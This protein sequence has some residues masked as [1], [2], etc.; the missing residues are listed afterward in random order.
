MLNENNKSRG[1]EY[2][3]TTKSSRFAVVFGVAVRRCPWWNRWR[4]RDEPGSERQTGAAGGRMDGRD[5]CLSSHSSSVS[6]LLPSCSR[7]SQPQ[8]RV[9]VG[10]DKRWERRSRAAS[11]QRESVTVFRLSYPS[12][13]MLNEKLHR[14][15]RANWAHT[16]TVGRDGFPA[17]FSAPECCSVDR[18]VQTEGKKVEYKLFFYR[19]IH[20]SLNWVNL[21]RIA[22]SLNRKLLTGFRRVK[23]KQDNQE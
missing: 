14:Q 11:C 23:N 10:E 12:V 21:V 19:W 7:R 17:F 13:L 3:G 22:D 16:V 20:C 4:T 18:N 2:G 6:H 9:A 15:Q 5:R 1:N 8:R